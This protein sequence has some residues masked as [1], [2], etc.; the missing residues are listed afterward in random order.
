MT[1]KIA[2]LAFAG[3]ALT[4]GGLQLVAF[5]SGGS[6]RHLI[7]GGFACVVGISVAAA[8]VASVLRSRR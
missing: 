8:V 6:P 7:L 4:A 3:L 5:A 1:L 2:A